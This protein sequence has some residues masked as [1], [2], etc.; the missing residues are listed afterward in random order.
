MISPCTL[1]VCNFGP[2]L[3]SANRTARNAPKPQASFKPECAPAITA[4]PDGNIQEKQK[5]AHQMHNHVTLA[6]HLQTSSVAKPP[7]THS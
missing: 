3:G 5:T 4:N 7:N 1:L 2:D 6:A